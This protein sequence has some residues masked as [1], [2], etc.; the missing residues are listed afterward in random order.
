MFSNRVSLLK[1]KIEKEK[2]DRILTQ[3]THNQTM[4]NL[5][6]ELK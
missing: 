6:K 4:A 1:E 3:Q 5:Q 2:Q